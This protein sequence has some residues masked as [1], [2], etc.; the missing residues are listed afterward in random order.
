MNRGFDRVGEVFEDIG[1][2]VR[3]PSFLKGKQNSSEE[4][5]QARL[6]TKIRCGVEM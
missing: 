6:V 3:M 4:A 2:E 1:L 5:D